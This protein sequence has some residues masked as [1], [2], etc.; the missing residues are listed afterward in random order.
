MGWIPIEDKYPL[1]GLQVLVEMSS[2]G[3]DKD[4]CQVMADHGFYIATWIVPEGKE[5]EWLIQTSTD[6]WKPN[7]HAWMPLPRHYAA[8]EVFSQEEDLLEHP[9][10]DEDPEWLY[11]GD[12]VYEQ[13]TLEEMM[14]L[15]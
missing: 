2:R 10:F 3:I 9:M 15:C 14:K 5:G 1:E 13:M 4:K 8:Q 11:K 6:F 7:V 12:C